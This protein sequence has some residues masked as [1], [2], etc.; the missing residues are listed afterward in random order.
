MGFLP[1]C[2]PT[3]VHA[4]HTWALGTS[5]QI[6]LVSVLQSLP[7]GREC[8]A[9]PTIRSSLR[10]W[11]EA[12]D[13][14]SRCFLA[15][16]LWGKSPLLSPPP[17]SPPPPSPRGLHF[18]FGEGVGRVSLSTRRWKLSQQPLPRPCYLSESKLKAFGFPTCPQPLSVKWWTGFMIDALLALYFHQQISQ[19]AALWILTNRQG[20]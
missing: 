6:E 13:N 18:M 17:D 11:L 14:I 9:T 4:A 8:L 15:P 19:S 10:W 7:I 3:S 2:P 12:G 5:S 16:D 1:S 20:L